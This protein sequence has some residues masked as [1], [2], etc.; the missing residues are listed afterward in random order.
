M[1]EAKLAETADDLPLPRFRRLLDRAAN[2]RGRN[3]INLRLPP[4]VNRQKIEESPALHARYVGLKL[5]YEH[6]FRQWLA[7]LDRATVNQWI[8]RAVLRAETAAKDLHGAKDADRRQVITA[9]AKG[10][11]RLDE[12][13]SLHSFCLRLS[14]ET[15]AEMR[16]QRGYESDGERAK[17]QAGFIEELLIDVLAQGFDRYLK[18][19][20]FGF[21]VDL[22]ADEPLPDAPKGKLLRPKPDNG[23]APNW[24]LLLYFLL[25]LVPVD[26]VGRLLHQIRK[27]KIVAGKAMNPPGS[28]GAPGSGDADVGQ[29]VRT[30]TLYL[31]MH[32][33]KFTGDQALLVLGPFKSLYASP[34]TFDRVFPKSSVDD[35]ER[36]P[37][38]GLREIMR[39]GHLPPLRHVFD[40]HKVADEMVDAVLAA[41]E[42]PVAAAQR[43]R[44]TLHETWA[45]EREKFRADDL[46]RYVEVLAEVTRHRHAAAHV[47]LVDHVRLHRLTMAV[48]GRLLDFAGLLER[49]LYFAM[50][51]LMYRKGM[52]PN[53][54]FN[55][56]GRKALGRGQIIEARRNLKD[57]AIEQELA[58]LFGP[59]YGPII[60]I[61][62]GFAHFNMLNVKR[63]GG[64][65]IDLTAAVNDARRMM[66]HDRK[67]KNAVAQSVIE[68]VEREGL[69]L[70]WRI[71]ASGGEHRLAGAE[72]GGRQ[73]RHLGKTVLRKKNGGGRKDRGQPVMESLHGDHL[74]AMVAMLF[75]GEPIPARADP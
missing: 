31:D 64:A 37:R 24:Q 4:P 16:V 63:S 58:R 43:E 35:D 54:A 21:L 13:E 9:R 2:I 50:L 39:F 51:A 25:H 14:R 38:R 72:V 60:D 62:N 53:E 66:A 5:L 44:E 52:S 73:A 34:E 42:G 45:R 69:E 40:A 26:D 65:A 11:G 33:A 19:Q 75:G 27:W 8:D 46:R 67:L 61:R 17:E 28:G 3:G 59:P 47:R 22:R 15:A 1:V 7:A 12:G 70:K 10:L 20:R 57:Q 55:R 18:E 29:V 49:D 23:A 56:G 68:L 48:L 6:P 36:L 74:V 71:E 32:D 41:E 30:L